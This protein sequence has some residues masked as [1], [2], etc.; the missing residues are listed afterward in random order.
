M[1]AVI[2]QFWCSLKLVYYMYVYIYICAK[3][4]Y[5]L[6]AVSGQQ[7]FQRRTTGLAHWFLFVSGGHCPPGADGERSG[8]LRET[9]SAGGF[10]SHP[11]PTQ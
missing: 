1:R 4:M 10:R 9:G 7:M 5:R 3:H 11:H 2:A 8:E 6:M